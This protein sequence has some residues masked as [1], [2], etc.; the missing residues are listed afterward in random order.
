MIVTLLRLTNAGLTGCLDEN[1]GMRKTATET[2]KADWEP[3]PEKVSEAVRL[4]AEAARP[5]SI[6]IFGSY[7]RGETTRDSDLDLLVIVDDSVKS[8]RGLAGDLLEKTAAVFMPVDIIVVRR[9]DLER[10]LR[11]PGNVCRSALREGIIAYG[12][13]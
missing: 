10:Q 13:I 2:A 8:P 7:A 4:I 1:C 6:V 11:I 12:S 5:L 3:T 9:S